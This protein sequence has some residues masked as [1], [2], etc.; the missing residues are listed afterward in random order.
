MIYADDGWVSQFRKAD[1]T[2]RSPIGRS[3]SSWREGFHLCLR[4]FSVRLSVK[5]SASVLLPEMRKSETDASVCA[6]A[7][8]AT[9]TTNNNSNNKGAQMIIC[10]A[11]NN[12]NNRVPVCL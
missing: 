12:N 1:P 5:L 6:I 9:A 10:G 8:F 2:A 11:P 4:V 3:S 7:C